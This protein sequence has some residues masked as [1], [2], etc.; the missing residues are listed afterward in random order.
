MKKRLLFVALMVITMS[1]LISTVA[2]AQTVSR[3][4]LSFGATTEVREKFLTGTAYQVTTQAIIIEIP[5]WTN[6]VTLTFLINNGYS[7]PLYEKAALPRGENVVFF[8]KR[9]LVGNEE[10]RFTLSGAPGGSGGT[11]WVTIYP[12]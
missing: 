2:I 3:F 1:I 12:E 11:I 7:V 5:T 8:I 9:K 6:N 10:L 4:D